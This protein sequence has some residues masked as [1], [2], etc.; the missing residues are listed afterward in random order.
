MNPYFAYSAVIASGLASIEEQVEPPPAYLGD[1]Y[2]APNET[3]LPAS[4][5]APVRSFEGSKLARS[6]FGEEV[7]EHYVHFFSTEA[8]AY[9]HAVTDWERVR[10]FERI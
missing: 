1:V 4:L 5:E 7:V 10:Y 3:L 8:Y 6:A 2:S 9:R